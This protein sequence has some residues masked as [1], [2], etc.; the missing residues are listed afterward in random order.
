MSEPVSESRKIQADPADVWALVSDLPRMGEWS[1]ENQGGKWLGG[2]DGPVVG[3]KFRGANRSGFHRWKT[4]V[5]ITQADPGERFGF[6]VDFLGIPVSAWSYAIEPTA[7]GCR[8]TET[9]TDRRPGFFKPLSHLAT[10]VADRADHSRAEMAHTLELL[11][12]EAEAS[13]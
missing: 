13:S 1:N 12:A 2:A 5:T 6:D 8:V 4:G 9:W 7:G 10:G 3:A 11:A